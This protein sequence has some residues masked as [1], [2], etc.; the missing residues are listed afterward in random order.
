MKEILVLLF[1]AVLGYFSKSNE[2]VYASIILALILFFG[3]IFE[4]FGIF[5]NLYKSES[6]MVFF[7]KYGLR[8]G[9]TFLMLYGLIPIARGEITFEHILKAITNWRAWVMIGV[10]ISITLFA[11]Q[12]TVFM[13]DNPDLLMFLVMGVICG[14]IIFK[15]QPVGPIIGCG[16]AYVCLLL[17]EK[18]IILFSRWLNGKV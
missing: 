7:K 9:I 1:L 11:S 12:G 16:I 2:V 6:I 3:M 10:G 18:V 8:I 5:T 17:I 14:V 15:G 13:K 4:H